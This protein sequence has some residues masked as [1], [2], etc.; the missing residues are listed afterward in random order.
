[1]GTRQIERMEDD[2]TA[3]TDETIAEDTIELAGGD[4]IDDPTYWEAIEAD[5]DEYA[6]LSDY[7]GAYPWITSIEVSHPDA[8]STVIRLHTY[9]EE[10]DPLE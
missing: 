7:A 9:A 4:D 1:M 6:Q 2:F 5:W 3:A 10:E 8:D